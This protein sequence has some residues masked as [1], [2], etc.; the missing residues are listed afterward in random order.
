MQNAITILLLLF[1]SGC[2]VKK[3]AMNQLANAL[4]AST[5][6]SFATDDDLEL[7]G[8]AIPFAL[9]LMESIHAETPEHV[10][11]NEALCAGFTQYAIV[12][13]QFPAE[14][15]YYDDFDSYS[16]NMD[17]AR[18]LLAR[19]R[20]YGFKGL[21]VRHPGFEAQLRS[22]RDAALARLESDDLGL[23]Y[24]T[25]AA[26][27]AA[28]STSLEDVGLIGEMPLAAGI[29]H[30]LLELEPGWA[31][32][33][34][35]EVLISLEP[36]LPLPGGQDRAREHYQRALALNGGTRASPHVSLATAVS[37]PN[38]D[39]AEFIDL[40]NKALAVDLSASSEDRLA[41]VY[42]QERARYLLDHLDDFFIE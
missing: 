1:L 11:L 30:R 37:K 41:K 26:W 29:M 15:A 12:W 13:V 5:T 33:S 39:R 34:I 28:I 38:Q 22:D 27:L 4:S 40:L 6:S 36:S 9:K 31:N 24:W 3:M 18:R 16:H 32:G 19:A 25:T 21:E 14:L 23:A 20:A 17:R 7:V 42:A 8:D 2:S 35:H 10:G